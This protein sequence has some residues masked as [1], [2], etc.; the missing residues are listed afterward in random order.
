MKELLAIVFL[1]GLSM[2]CQSETGLSSNGTL[3]WV[4]LPELPNT[5][6]FAG[7]FAGIC[8][9]KLVV[10]GGANFPDKKPWEGGKKVWY[11]TVFVLDKTNGSWKIVGKLPRPLGY[12]VS[13]STSDGIICIGGSDEKRHYADCFLLSLENDKVSIKKLP[14][15]P[16]PLANM[17]GAQVNDAIYICGGSDEPGEKSALNRLFM[18]SIKKQNDGWKELEPCPGKPRILPIAASIDGCFIIAGGANIIRNNGSYSREYLNDV[19]CYQDGKGWR[20]LP[21]M[22]RPLVAASSPA[23]LFDSKIYIFGGDDG[24]N[25][26][27]QPQ[28]SNL[29]FS[30]Q[31][32]VFNPS[33]NSWQVIGGCPAPRA[34]FPVVK[35]DNMFVMISGEL[36]PGVRSPEI[37]GL[38]V[39]GSPH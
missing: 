11:D 36:R 31:V 22:P 5:E 20:K 21:D 26:G 6:G 12:G 23:V 39:N 27:K 13:V 37:W 7:A 4:K 24:S 30:K 15:L 9:G 29:G 2:G 32:F 34:V 28:S 14:S 35:W 18:L 3:K 8:D 25:I 17:A 10:A 33:E 16:V 1:L 38:I 19:W